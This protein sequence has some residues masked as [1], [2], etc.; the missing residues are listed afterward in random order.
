[1]G[2][3]QGE[4]VLQEGNSHVQDQEEEGHTLD[5]EL[6][7]QGREHDPCLGTGDIIDPDQGHTQEEEVKDQHLEKEGGVRVVDLGQNQRK[8]HNQGILHQYPM[9]Q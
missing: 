9:C 6:E 5:Q 7:P 2:H 8:K 4:G 1:M 3:L